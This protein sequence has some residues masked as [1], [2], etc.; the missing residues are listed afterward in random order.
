M[1]QKW[2]LPIKTVSE[3]NISEH[4]TKSSKR[5]NSQAFSIRY[6]FKNASPKFNLPLAITLTRLSPRK[7]DSDNL[8][9]AFK[10]IKDAIADQIFPGLAAGRADD[11]P[12]LTW[13]YKQENAKSYGIRIEFSD[14]I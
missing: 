8:V 2:E 9:I 14:N 5:H 6:W 12:E 3:A 13:H 7:L 4:W 11:S 10:W 1:I